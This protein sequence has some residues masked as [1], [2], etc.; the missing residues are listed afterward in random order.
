MLFRERI[1]VVRACEN[2][3]RALQALT[4]ERAGILFAQKGLGAQPDLLSASMRRRIVHEV[5]VLDAL[6]AGGDGSLD[7]RRRIGV[8]RDIGLAVGCGLDR[9]AQFGLVIG[10]HVERRPRR[11][12][13]SAAREL[14]LRSALQELFASPQPHFVAAVGDARRARP[15]DDG[16]W[17]PAMRGMSVSGRR[18][19]WPPL[20]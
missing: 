9:G 10:D 17:S 2:P 19:P 18:S 13:A 11:R 3:K 4:G 12:H 7:R 16:R 1:D 8:H 6:R 15:L 14:D 5:A 20:L